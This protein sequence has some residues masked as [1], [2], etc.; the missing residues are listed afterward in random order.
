MTASADPE[1]ADFFMTGYDYLEEIGSVRDYFD[2]SEDFDL[3][4]IKSL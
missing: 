1:L 4:F 3:S 2:E